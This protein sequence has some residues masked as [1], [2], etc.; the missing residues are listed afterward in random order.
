MSLADRLAK[1]QMKD[2]IADVR[3]RV[4]E[5]LVSQPT[6]KLALRMPPPEKHSALS[7]AWRHSV[8]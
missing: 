3:S 6:A 2:R 5:R 1:A 8:W 4:Q 7:G